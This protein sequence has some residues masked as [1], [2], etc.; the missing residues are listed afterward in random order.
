MSLFFWVSTAG[1]A[2]VRGG[3]ECERFCISCQSLVVVKAS[4]WWAV[5]V[6][7]RVTCLVMWGRG[8]INYSQTS[9]TLDRNR[10]AVRHPW[11]HCVVCACQYVEWGGYRSKK[12]TVHSDPQFLHRKWKVGRGGPQGLLLARIF[13][14]WRLDAWKHHRVWGFQM[15]I[16]GNA[17]FSVSQQ[18]CPSLPL[19]PAE[20]WK[21]PTFPPGLPSWLS[22]PLPGCTAPA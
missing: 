5:V 4:D 10:E 14:S 6:Y 19:K 11:L 2:L 20:A 7:S 13:S 12:G 18:Y 15:R 22:S 9:E 17:G 3:E 1:V 16:A 8:W 21:A